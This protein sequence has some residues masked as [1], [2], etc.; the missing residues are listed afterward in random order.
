VTRPI[1]SFYFCVLHMFSRLTLLFKEAV[2]VMIITVNF[3]HY[4]G[5]IA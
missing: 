5:D 1:L 2:G 3:I 4:S